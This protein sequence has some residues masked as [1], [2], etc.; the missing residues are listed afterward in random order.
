[1]SLEE[2]EGAELKGELDKAAYWRRK[3]IK[4]NFL[5][6]ADNEMP[7][8]DSPDGEEEDEEEMLRR[9][10]AMSLQEEEEELKGELP[11]K[12]DCQQKQWNSTF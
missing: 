9:A 5:A 1:M 12:A 11:M 7:A 4:F 6:D 2:E 3:T 10:I 8:T